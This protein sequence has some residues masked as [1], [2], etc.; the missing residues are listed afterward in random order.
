MFAGLFVLG[1]YLF[2][3]VWLLVLVGG[4]VGFVCVGVLGCFCLVVICLAACG[5][6]IWFVDW[7]C[8]LR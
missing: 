7:F 5:F 1:I 3:V 4:V 6:W 8:V 2:G